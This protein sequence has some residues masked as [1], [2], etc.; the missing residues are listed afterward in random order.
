MTICLVDTNVFCNVLEVPGFCQHRD[1][2]LAELEEVVNAGWN[3]LLPV[4]AILETGNHIARAAN[5]H[6]RRQ[7]AN[8]FVDQVEKALNGEAPWVI[9]PLPGKETWSQ[10]LGDFPDHASA[11]REFGD[12]SIIQEFYQQCALHP[13]RRVLIWSRD[14]DLQGY[15]RT[16]V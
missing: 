6:H 10:W 16:G 1:E 15:D 3:L 9:T 12:L 8:R 11:G 2:V 13:K 4:A 14:G 5:G 7:A